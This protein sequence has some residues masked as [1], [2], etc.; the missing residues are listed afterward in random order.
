MTAIN[1]G[2]GDLRKFY[3]GGTACLEVQIPTLSNTIF[4]RKSNPYIHLPQ[5]MVPQPFTYL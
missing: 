2:W 4:D 3:T 1:L 5:E